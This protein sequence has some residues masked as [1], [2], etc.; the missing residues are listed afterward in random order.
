MMLIIRFPVESF[1]ISFALCTMG[2]TVAIKPTDNPHTLPAVRPAAGYGRSLRR[3][4]NR[5]DVFHL[6]NIDL[7]DVFRA[8]SPRKSR[9]PQRFEKGTLLD[10]YA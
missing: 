6:D 7:P 10:T 2:Q 8:S 9:S 1:H 5:T 4:P 3:V